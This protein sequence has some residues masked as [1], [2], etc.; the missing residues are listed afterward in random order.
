MRQQRSH[1]SSRTNTSLS[2]GLNL[3]SS[4]IRT[5]SV[6]LSLASR[7]FD[8]MLQPK[9]NEGQVLAEHRTVEV[10]LPDDDPA[11]MLAL[12]RVLHYRTSDLGN[13]TCD[14]LLDIAVL[15]DKYDCARALHT[16]LEHWLEQRSLHA[17]HAE[18]QQL[19]AAAYLVRNSAQFRR[20]AVDLVM[21]ST[22]AVDSASSVSLWSV[23]RRSSCARRSLPRAKV[24]QLAGEIEVQ[25]RAT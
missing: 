21:Y 5:S 12:C 20:R 23:T 6:V 22:E 7:V 2:P 14:T 8:A 11:A 9:F 15:S 3:R 4:K 25:R 17:S 19:L 16:I 18:R 10:P 24:D 13:L 1:V